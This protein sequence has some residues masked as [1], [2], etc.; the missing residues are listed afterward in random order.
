MRA[1]DAGSFNTTVLYHDPE[2]GVEYRVTWYD[3]SGQPARD[4]WQALES[5]YLVL[6]PPG[7]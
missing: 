4:A 1:T 6:V 2:S 5:S 7:L 3:Q